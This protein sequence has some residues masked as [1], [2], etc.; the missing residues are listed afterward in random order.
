MPLTT[1]ELIGTPA[2]ADETDLNR[3]VD[4]GKKATGGG[5]AI[6]V[7]KIVVCATVGGNWALATAGSTGTMGIIPKL[8]PVN[9]DSDT[10]I[11][12]VHRALAEYYAEA[13]G[14]ITVNADVVADTGGKVKQRAAEA[15]NCV[16]GK[17]MG[18]Y[19]EGSL[20]GSGVPT[21][22]IATDAV[23]IRFKGGST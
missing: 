2:Y 22:A 13:N 21:N 16:V 18:H 19:G 1:A 5:S 8:D 12:V 20:S 10:T 7:G 3:S 6:A 14:N 15:D 17:Y 11:N 9:G 4:S 23:R